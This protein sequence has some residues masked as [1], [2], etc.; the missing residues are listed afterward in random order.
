MYVF[1]ILACCANV[2]DPAKSPVFVIADQRVLNLIIE[3][4]M[5]WFLP[6]RC[7][8]TWNWGLLQGVE[9]RIIF[10]LFYCYLKFLK[11]SQWRFFLTFS[12]GKLCNEVSLA[13]KYF[14]W[15]L[16]PRIRIPQSCT[17]TFSNLPQLEVFIRSLILMQVFVFQATCKAF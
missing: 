7:R 5:I 14:W 2:R 13:K 11:K 6:P 15:A 8:N 17:L 9:S 4:G 1:Q 12:E 3:R 10:P 16:I